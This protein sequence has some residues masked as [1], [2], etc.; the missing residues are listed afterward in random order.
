MSR[1]NSPAPSR[2]ARGDWLSFGCPLGTERELLDEITLT[3][4]SLLLFV[5][6]A[7]LGALVFSS[8]LSPPLAFQAVIGVGVASHYSPVQASSASSALTLRCSSAALRH[9]RCGAVNNLS[10]RWSFD[11]P[12]ILSVT[13]D[14]SHSRSSRA[15]GTS[16][17]FAF[18]RSLQTTAS[19]SDSVTSAALLLF[20]LGLLALGL[21][22]SS[23][24]D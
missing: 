10:N 4:C 3:H 24:L 15:A 22:L 18:S 8:F 12:A 19:V 14:S 9:E 17:V 21:A 7:A 16:P 23:H 11:C 13:P 2:C 5:R 20:L 1:V 6:R